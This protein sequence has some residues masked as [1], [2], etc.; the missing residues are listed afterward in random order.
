MGHTYLFGKLRIPVAGKQLQR[1]HIRKIDPAAY[2]TLVLDQISPGDEAD[3]HALDLCLHPV[4]PNLVE[5]H[6]P[7]GRQQV[8]PPV[9][10]MEL[11]VLTIIQEIGRL[12]AVQRSPQRLQRVEDRLGVLDRRPKEH[13]EVTRIPHKAVRVHRHPAHNGVLS[14]GRVQ[15]GEESRSPS[16]SSQPAITRSASDREAQYSASSRRSSS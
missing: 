13:I 11:V 12:D 9:F 4:T 5:V 1:L 10:C 16:A 6:L 2:L 8:D 3:G 7:D 15:R 14:P